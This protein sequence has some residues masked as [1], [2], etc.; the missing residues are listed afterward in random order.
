MVVN[1]T[2]DDLTNIRAGD[3]PVDFS[4]DIPRE[5]EQA[6]QYGMTPYNPFQ[7]QKLQT[8]DAQCM[9]RMLTIKRPKV[10]SGTIW[11]TEA[12]FAETL[13]LLPLNKIEQARFWRKFRKI[14]MLASGECNKKI[15]DTKQERL[16]EELISQKS[17]LDVS[18]NGNLNEREMWVTTRQQIEQT[19]KVPQ[20][21]QQRG[22]FSSV[23]GG[24]TGR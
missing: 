2:L 5:D 15:V 4:V 21:S 10:P 24:I 14:Q 22:F 8:W 7:S 12:S 13:S 11:I 23:L 1:V 20:T 3:R 19:M 17:R 9:D 6:M 18:P 16:M